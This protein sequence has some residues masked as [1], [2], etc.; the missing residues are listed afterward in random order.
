MA[1]TVDFPQPVNPSTCP[2][3][4]NTGHLIKIVNPNYVWYGVGEKFAGTPFGIYTGTLNYFDQEFG[5]SSHY[6]ITIY[7][8]F[9]SVSSF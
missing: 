4:E 9:R 8:K 2:F 5:S 7:D 1:E 6:G 3:A